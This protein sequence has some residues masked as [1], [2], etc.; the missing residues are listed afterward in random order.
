MTP[1]TDFLVGLVVAV[2]ALEGLL[3]CMDTGV[4]AEVGFIVAAMRTVG[5]RKRLLSRVRYH[6]LVK[7]T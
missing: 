7:V 3:A 4:L 6:V 2:G 1:H 5:A